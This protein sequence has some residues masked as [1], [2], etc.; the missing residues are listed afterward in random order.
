MILKDAAQVLHV[1]EQGN[2]SLVAVML[3]R[4]LG[5]FRVHIKGARRWPKKGFE[6]GFD[7]LTRGE[8][9]VYPRGGDSL[10]V[11]KEWDERARP[12]IGRTVAMLRSASYL[13][14]LAEALTRHTAGSRHDEFS[15]RHAGNVDDSPSAPLYDLLA[16]AAD[17][18]A[19][20]AR[21][22]SLLLGYTLH[23]LESEGLLPDLNA[24][25]AC[26]RDLQKI[27]QERRKAPPVQSRGLG[28][29][30]IG[31]GSQRLTEAARGTP[32]AA[33][34]NLHAV[35][36]AGSGLR[37]QE[38]VAAGQE[39]GE[40]IERGEWLSPEAHRVLVHTHRS[41]RAVT[42]SVLASR[43]L[44]RALIVLVHGALESDLRTLVGAARMVALMGNPK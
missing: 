9:L 14:E 36:L 8:L 19:A 16:A 39:R 13:C 26:H 6:G 5:Q 22:G 33:T 34:P 25:A 24:C 12:A 17:A 27:R 18:L 20:G 30:R 10:W 3:G 2:T 4:R 42:V 31:T 15:A 38:C 40:P 7:L 35:W 32:L 21:P 1:Y 29:S 37:C 28:V 41:A 11:F 23:A 43:Q 44:A